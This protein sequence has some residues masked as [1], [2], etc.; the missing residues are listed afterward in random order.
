MAFAQRRLRVVVTPTLSAA[1]T[2]TAAVSA[3]A[4]FAG[5]EALPV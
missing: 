5:A 3:T 1:A 2:D 4:A